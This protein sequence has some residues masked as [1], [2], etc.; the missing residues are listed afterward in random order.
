MLIPIVIVIIAIT[1][2]C[3]FLNALF[4]YAVAQPGRPEIRPAGREAR[5]RIA[6]IALTGVLLGALLAFSTTIVTRWGAAVVHDLARRDGGSDDAP[7]RRAA[8]AADRSLA[9]AVPA[10]K[11]WTTIVSGA[12]SVTV[13]TPPYALGRVGVLML[14]SKVRL[15]PGLLVLA[16]GVTLQ[17]GA[18]GAVSALKLSVTLMLVCA[19]RR[20]QRCAG[21]RSPPHPSTMRSEHAGHPSERSER[22]RPPPA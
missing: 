18:T 1:V 11:L 13:C 8:G 19:A 3:F 17:A 21:G 14:G 22:A 15:I 4:A 6:P 5:A 2:G 20:R 7:L 9:G 12:I 16:V 10:D